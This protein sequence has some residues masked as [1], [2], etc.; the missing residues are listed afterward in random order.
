MSYI[1]NSFF[2]FTKEQ[3]SLI[4]ILEKKFLPHFC[5]EDYRFSDNDEGLDYHKLA[6]PMVCFCDIPLSNISEHMNCY[7]KFAI[8]MKHE[9]GERY[10]NPVFYLQNHSTPCKS[11]KIIEEYL[12]GTKKEFGKEMF[13]NFLDFTAYLKSYKGRDDKN[14]S[15]GKVFYKERE[16][17]WVPEISQEEYLENKVLRAPQKYVTD[18]KKFNESIQ[19]K[20]KLNFTTDDIQYIIVDKDS[21]KKELIKKIMKLKN[22]E[23]SNEIKLILLTKI[24][25]IEEISNDY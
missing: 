6:V 25:S 7:G 3:D 16:W 21:R 13:Y 20:Y 17:R 15:K 18:I 5:F 22:K 14:G 9:W 4:N 23:Y 8:G 10:L 19:K 1:A 12:L 24:T 2:H 11:Y